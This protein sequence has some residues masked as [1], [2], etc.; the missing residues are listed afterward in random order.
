MGYFHA[1][2][3]FDDYDVGGVAKN[4]ADHISRSFPHAALLLVRYV[5]LYFNC[6]DLYILLFDS[7]FSAV[8]SQKT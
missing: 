7:C 4:I 6:S 1:N 3:R 8:R 5:L 2:E